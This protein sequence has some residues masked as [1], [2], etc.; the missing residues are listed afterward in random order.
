MSKTL[1]RML[2]KSKMTKEDL[3][4]HLKS[5]KGKG[6]LKAPKR[7]V[8]D[9]AELRRILD[10]PRRS[11]EAG[12]ADYV[13]VLTQHLRTPQGQQRL[14]PIQAAALVEAHD[15][16]GLIGSI[17][18][19]GGKCVC[20]G[21]E[22]FD[23]SD[24]RRRFV[25]DLGSFHTVSMREGEGTLEVARATSVRSGAKDC[26][27]LT[28]TNG[29]ALEASFDHPIYTARGWVWLRD[30]AEQDLVATARTIP[31]P[32]RFTEASDDEVKLAAYLLADGSVSQSSTTF[33]DD[34]EATLCE[35]ENIVTRLGGSTSRGKERG[36]C[37]RLNIRGMKGF[38]NKWG[39]HGLSKDKRVP[40]SFWGLRQEHV[41]LFLNRFW[42]CDGYHVPGRGFE[43]CLAS[44]RLIDDLQFLL[45]RLGIKSRKKYKQA[46]AGGK[47][48]DAWRLSVRGDD[49]L[50]FY[51][52]VG[53]VFGSEN[54]SDEIASQLRATKRNTNTDVVP[55]GTESLP[56]IYQELGV[57]K[58]QGRGE[59]RQR[60][61]ATGGQKVSRSLF[62]EA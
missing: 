50:R 17:R 35:V 52:V 44:S 1:D 40:P 18:V 23:A 56:T 41:A 51:S 24:G 14:R 13:E 33:V 28:L 6:L 47:L 5:P 54:K 25:E 46:R 48:F 55:I 42:A 26:Y 20:A 34:N 37:E 12:A 9:S 11:W 36:N 58:G 19:G 38:R 10:L 43:V 2:E 39:I 16:R 15:W 7:A 21:T 8:E 49:A 61:S 45:L 30:L 59:I 27:R 22:V 60:L 29:M 57:D 4:R 31:D 3:Q 32:V 62:A 53:P